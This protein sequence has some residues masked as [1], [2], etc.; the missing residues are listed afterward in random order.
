MQGA[1]QKLG[2]NYLILR[3][4]E[5]SN[6]LDFFKTETFIWIKMKVF[7]NFVINTMFH[8]KKIATSVSGIFF[9]GYNEY[10]PYFLT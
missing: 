1:I 7:P 3:V 5:S 8:S 4:M 2:C 9:C 10:V 6:E